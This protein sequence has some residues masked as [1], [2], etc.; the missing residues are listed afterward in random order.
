MGFVTFRCE[1]I[2]GG[3]NVCV[4]LF[5]L[6]HYGSTF[7]SVWYQAFTSRNQ[8]SYSSVGLRSPIPYGWYKSSPHLGPGGWFLTGKLILPT[9]WAE[10]NSLVIS[11]GQHR[12][13]WLSFP[14]QFS[15]LLGPNVT[16]PVPAWT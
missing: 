3:I 15:T 13:F 4:L 10:T 7:G 1:V 11:L 2:I 9:A 5:P 12:V 8:F 6:R 16:C 14:F